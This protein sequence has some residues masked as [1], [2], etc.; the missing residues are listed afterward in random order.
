[1]TKLQ[2]T[3]GLRLYVLSV[4]R[5]FMRTQSLTTVYMQCTYSVYTV[6]TAVCSVLAVYEQPTLQVHCMCCSVPA[7]YLQC[8]L[9][10]TA[11]TLHDSSIYDGLL[12]LFLYDRCSFS[13]LLK[14]CRARGPPHY[15]PMGL[16]WLD[17]NANSN[18]TALL[19]RVMI[20]LVEPHWWP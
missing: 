11:G 18:E 13:I 3:T 5:I 19:V 15:R 10:G 2:C 16:L 4:P 9:H 20:C 17:T 12:C 1:M 6:Y 7:V 8:T 14:Q